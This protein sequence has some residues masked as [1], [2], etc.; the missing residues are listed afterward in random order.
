MFLV[1]IFQFLTSAIIFSTGRPFRKPIFTN[2]TLT[3][4]LCFGFAF[5]LYVVLGRNEDVNDIFAVI[6]FFVY[7]L[8]LVDF[9][10]DHNFNLIIL[11]FVL[12]NIILSCL[13]EGIIVKLIYIN[14]EKKKKE[15][16]KQKVTRKCTTL[17]L[18]L[19]K[20]SKTKL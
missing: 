11:G 3:I 10:H 13:A 20:K 1:S 17:S 8:K 15:F 6:I 12:G 16:L 14:W 18:Q 19:L 4:Y 2:K 9:E 5:L 7:L